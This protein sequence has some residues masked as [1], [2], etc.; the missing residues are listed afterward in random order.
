MKKFIIFF[1]IIMGLCPLSSFGSNFTDYINSPIVHEQSKNELR[2]QWREVFGCDIFK[3][4]FVI[5]DLEDSFREYTAINFGQLKGRLRIGE[6]Y[7][8]IEYKFKYEF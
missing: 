5:K 7:K 2:I 3:S 6:N 4:Y 8:A 1:L